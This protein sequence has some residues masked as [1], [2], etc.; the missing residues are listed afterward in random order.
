MF[1]V[2][3]SMTIFCHNE[4]IFF[5]QVGSIPEKGNG[6][7]LLH[8]L[9]VGIFLWSGCHHKKHQL[10][11]TAQNYYQLAQAELQDT[12]ST[13]DRYRKSLVY[14]DRALKHEIRSEYLATKAMILHSLGRLEEAES[15]MAESM[16]MCCDEQMKMAL[17]NNY[18]CILASQNKTEEAFQIWDELVHNPLYPTPEVARYNQS[19]ILIHQ[20]KLKRAAI[21]LEEALGKAPDY[22]DAHYYYGLVSYV[23]GDHH[24]ASYHANMVLSY[25]QAHHGA[26]ELQRKLLS[27]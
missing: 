9:V 13:F 6:M 1:D 26:L 4:R 27:V 8:L 17:K 18:A 24:K 20:G 11:E 2:H 21:V 12:G 5:N 15:V 19:K 14:I 23:L 22:I 7:K 3:I 10:L 16:K 25:E